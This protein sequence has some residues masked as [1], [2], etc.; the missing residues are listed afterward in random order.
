MRDVKLVRGAFVLAR[1]AVDAVKQWAYKPYY[2][3]GQPVEAQTLITVN[4]RLPSPGPNSGT[5]SVEIVSSRSL[6]SAKP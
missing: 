6:D 3:S 2:V 5:P 4:F 1:A